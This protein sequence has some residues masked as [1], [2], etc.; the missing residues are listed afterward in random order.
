MKHL[1]LATA[2]AA[3]ALTGCN[4]IQFQS[5]IKKVDAKPMVEHEHKKGEHHHG[6]PMHKHH[7]K[8]A[9]FQ[10]KCESK[11]S[12]AVK[13]DSDNELANVNVTAPTLGL[14]DQDIQLQLA[15]SASGERYVND[16]NPAS[17]YEWHA[18]GHE[19]V[20]SVNV[21]GKDYDLSCEAVKPAN[22]P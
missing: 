7:H 20:F 1:L 10:Y 19:G 11:A 21:G 4:N 15:P 17:I 14:T 22:H 5:P 13:Y 2:V 9:T 12:L 8:G 16:T 18:K 6:K 3:V